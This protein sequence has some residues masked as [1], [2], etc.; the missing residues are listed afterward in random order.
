M[1]ADLLKTGTSQ[2]IQQVLKRFSKMPNSAKN[3][4]YRELYEICKPPFVHDYEGYAEHAF[5]D[6]HGQSSTPV[7]KAQA[8]SNY[9]IRPE[10]PSFS[11]QFCNFI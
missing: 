7:Q 10:K 6:Q 3:A 2:E 9:L 11:R 4:I 8:I 5:Y 1:I